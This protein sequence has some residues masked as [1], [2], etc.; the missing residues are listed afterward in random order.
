MQD[1]VPDLLALDPAL[2]VRSLE[3]RLL[4]IRPFPTRV[5]TIR[6]SRNCSLC[7]YAFAF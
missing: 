3:I 4:D 5:V 2:D 6:L 7:V 1:P